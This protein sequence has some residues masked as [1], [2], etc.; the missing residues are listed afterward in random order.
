[1]DRISAW[2]A[3]LPGWSVVGLCESPIK[4]PEGNKEFLIVGRFEG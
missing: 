1:C 4:G 3:A 2:L